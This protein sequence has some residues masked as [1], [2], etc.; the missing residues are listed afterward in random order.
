LFDKNKKILAQAQ[1]F[2]D[3]TT[4]NLTGFR[5]PP[6]L[7]ALG[8]VRQSHCRQGKSRRRDSA[9]FLAGKGARSSP[10]SA[11]PPLLTVMAVEPSY[12]Q[13]SRGR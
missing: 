7:S 5:D 9:L 10:T 2:S 4:K 12:P 11:V 13:D 3:T 8:R 1:W 6:G